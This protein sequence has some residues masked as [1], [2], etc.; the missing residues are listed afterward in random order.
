M[1]VTA[2]IVEVQLRAQ[3][4]GYIRDVKAAD[5]AFANATTHIQQNATK[6]SN[7]LNN[8]N[9][10]NIA[11][12]FQDIGVTAA[13]G[14]NPL[15]IALQ[16]GT[17][18]A[19]VLNQTAATGGN[20]WRTFGTA[21][22]S[23]INPISLATIATIALG[24]AAVQWLTSLQSSA[25]TATETIKRHREE[26]SSIV[27]GYGAAEDAVDAYFDS[28]SKLPQ[29][30]AIARTRDQF[31]EIGIEVERFRQQAELLGANPFFQT[32]GEAERA[33]SDL[34]ARFADGS[35]SAE[36]FY[37]ELDSLY[38]SLSDV[39]RALG[40]V[41]NSVASVIQSM[42]AGAEQAI[43]FAS[44]INNLVAASH[45]LSGLA[46]DSDLQN[47]LD[48]NTYVAE[49]ERLNS[50]TSDQLSLER[51]IARIK[52]E[53]GE[54]GITDDRAKVLAEQT[55]AA[56]QRRADL[57]K[58]MQEQ[59]RAGGKAASDA[60]K[61]LEA[62][63]ELIAQLEF[64]QSIVGM[65]NVDKAVA[66]AL[67]EAGAAATEEQRAQI[68]A[69]ISA[70][71]S[72]QEAIRA[73]DQIS[74]EWSNTLQSATRG[75]INDLIEGKSAAEAFG[76]VLSSIA[77]KLIDMGL[78]S[79]FSGSGIGDILGG[80]FGG[81]RASGGPVSGGTTY[82]VGEK[83]PELFTPSTAGNITPNNALGGGGSVVFSPVIDAR[84]ADVAAVARLEQ[85]IQRLAAEIVPT[86]RKEIANGPKKG[87]R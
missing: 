65:S 8:M 1:A 3:T 66:N 44:A 27:E 26:L 29:T 28:V 81:G 17:Q 57:R 2:D 60:Q 73:L 72:E 69:L 25:E 52:K 10:G 41:P 7:A 9:V 70:T 46:I 56:E 40:F 58:Q 5:A 43:A 38:N 64:E 76:N 19:A 80:I 33:V 35:L 61:E 16:Q 59:G 36:D 84:G 11:A 21:A 23:V 30:L 32:G 39:D 14:M 54:F 63:K 50:L 6:A 79:I 22:L 18:L 82:L 31:A 77:N 85:T 55:L 34:A 83:G 51:E 87:R 12:Q 78:N 75:F 42:Q 4:A 24:T 45:A 47:V 62:V 71:Y 20:V 67:R 53:A 74:K 13:A 68:E 37:S 15:L 86:I 48:L 49:Q